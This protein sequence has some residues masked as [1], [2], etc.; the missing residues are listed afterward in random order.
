MTADES[1]IAIRTAR[2]DDL[3]RLTEIYNHYIINTPITFDIDPVTVAERH[4][5]FEQ[6]S[7]AGRHRLFVAEEA[8]VVLGYAGSHQFRVKKAYDTTV[9]TSIYCAHEATGR[10]IGSALYT[11]LFEALRAEDIHM[12]MAGITMPNAASAA[13]HDRFGFAP[14]GIMHAVGYKFSQYWDVAWY[15]KRV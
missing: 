2:L 10:G 15:E 12:I 9:E 4:P 11:A 14:V 7:E 8:N 13:L 5:W 6:F 1:A 3:P